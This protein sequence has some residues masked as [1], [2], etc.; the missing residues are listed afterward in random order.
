M[1][2]DNQV[3]K[4]DDE[5]VRERVRWVIDLSNAERIYQDDDR[6]GVYPRSAWERLRLYCYENK[7]FIVNMYLQFRSN[8]VNCL[9]TNA[10]AYFFSHQVIGVFGS[11]I[12]IGCY[13]VGHV[14]E[15][16]ETV[17]VQQWKTPELILLGEEDRVADFNS[18]TIISREGYGLENTNR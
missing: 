3:C 12:T 8:V 13:L 1:I 14:N 10:P 17:R 15:N 18:L 7:V 16:S 2:N 6:P 9:P 4:T 11:D 5:Y